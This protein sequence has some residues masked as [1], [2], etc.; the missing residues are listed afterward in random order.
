[1]KMKMKTAGG[2]KQYRETTVGGKLI[3]KTKVF[4]VLQIWKH[5]M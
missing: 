2:E 4:E 5:E 1:M 3:L